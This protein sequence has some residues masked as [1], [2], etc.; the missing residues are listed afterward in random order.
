MGV[1]IHGRTGLKCDPFN[2]ESNGS[3][4]RI[5]NAANYN[6]ILSISSTFNILY[7]RTFLSESWTR[8]MMINVHYNI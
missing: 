3:E 4:D 8:H 7:Q 1:D 2:L 5:G 6:G